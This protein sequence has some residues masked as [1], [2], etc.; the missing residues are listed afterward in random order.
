MTLCNFEFVSCVKVDSHVSISGVCYQSSDLRHTCMGERE[1]KKV[2][3]RRGG[4][5]ERDVSKSLYMCVLLLQLLYS[6]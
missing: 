3:M 5:G 2:G 4:E 1:G 6:T